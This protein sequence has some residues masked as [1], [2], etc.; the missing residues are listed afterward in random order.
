[1]T[2]RNDDKA[3][4]LA[5]LT[6]STGHV[7]DLETEWLLSAVTTP[8]SAQVND[9]WMELFVQQG[10]SATDFNGAAYEFLGDLGYTGALPNRWA[11]YWKAGGGGVTPAYE[12]GMMTFDGSSGYY[13]KTGVTTSG[14]L[15]TATLRFN[16]ASF[17][18]GANE[19]GAIAFKA[20]GS[21][22]IMHF[23]FFPSDWAAAAR[24]DKLRVLVQNSAGTI[25]CQL[26]SIDDV[27]DGADHMSFFA[28][29]GD[30]GTA[31]FYIDG[32]D[33]DDTG[34]AD[35]I[36]P[37]TGTLPSGSDMVV[38]YGANPVPSNYADADIG[39][40]G[41]RLAYLTNPTDFYHPTNGLQE[42]DESGWTEWGA[43]PLFWNQYGTMTDNKGSGGNMTA[44]GTITGPA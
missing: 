42:L 32:V 43:Q 11:A 25:I 19:I 41:F 8:V 33:A 17:T 39:Y 28:F 29:D 30:A 34:N 27:M 36:A 37:T 10:V 5:T 13:S 44:N 26:F 40:S 21:A 35:R 22:A 2:H 9:L 7:D 15:I 23:T 24:R 4:A 1:M 38:S 18:G 3:S 14:N 31:V 6:G 20:A 16:R 12:P